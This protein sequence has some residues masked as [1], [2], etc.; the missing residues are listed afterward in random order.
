[1]ANA[2][3]LIKL[4]ISLGPDIIKFIRSIEELFPEQGKGAEKL[5]ILRGYLEAAWQGFGTAVPA[6]EE[7]WPRL[8]TVIDAIVST[9]NAIGIFKK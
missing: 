3:A 5:A 8:K 9:F 7:F 2:I 1:M 6:F 4:L